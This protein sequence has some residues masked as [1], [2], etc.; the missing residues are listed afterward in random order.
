MSMVNAGFPCP[1]RSDTTLTGTPALM[2]S[3]PWVCLMSWSRTLGTPALAEIRS[4]VWEIECGCTGLP[5]VLVN[6]QPSDSTPAASC[7]VVCHSRHA[8]STLMVVG[9]RSMARLELGVLPRDSCSS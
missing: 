5:S 8:F 2:S 7:S 1:S 6:T 3:V 4:K 9:S